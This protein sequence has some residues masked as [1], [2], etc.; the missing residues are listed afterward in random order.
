MLL[1]INKINTIPAKWI[2][3]ESSPDTELGSWCS[4][5]VC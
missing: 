4:E 3:A 1:H 2:F 5:S